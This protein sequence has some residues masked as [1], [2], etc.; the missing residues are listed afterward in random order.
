MIIID[1][2]AIAISNIVVQK[3]DIQED[4][5][6]H[7]ILNS[8]RMYRKKFQAEYGEIVITTDGQKNWRYDAFPNYKA[9]RQSDRKESSI[10]WKEAFR[11]TNLVF[12]E[13]SENF[14]YKTVNVDQVEADDIVAQLVEYT[15]EFGNWEKV[16]IVSG[17]KDFAQLQRYEN[18]FQFSPVLKKF[19]KE[20]NPRKQLLELVLKG[21]TSDGVPNV[22]S[23]DNSFV[24]GIRQTPLRQ[25]VIDQLIEDPKCMGEEVYRNFLRNK[26]LI[27]LS[28]T[29]E[30]LK[31]E[32][33]YNYS[34]QSE[35]G[36]V[37]KVFPYLVEK[38][39]RR[40]LEDVKD[41]V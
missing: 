27:D 36:N 34:N 15:Q 31:T 11:I 35:G 1:Y 24:D 14:P 7:M 17:D 26:K 41:F 9:R 8:I 32:I 22:L 6:R 3:L 10:D 40:L 29:P 37:N 19:I 33:I 13:I 25:K 30:T 20:P 18:V 23:P 38:R 4:M 16:M 5:I 2:N 21:D 28:E 12:Q 39:C